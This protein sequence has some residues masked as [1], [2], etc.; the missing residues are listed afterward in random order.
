MVTKINAKTFNGAGNVHNG[1]LAKA[2][3]AVAAA[4]SR[5][6][7]AS[8]SDIT[9]NGGGTNDAAGVKKFTPFTAFQAGTGDGV[10][11]T[12]F[13]AS[14]G[15]VRDALKEIAAQV[16]V[17]RAKVPGFAALTDS[18]GGT[19]ADGTIAAIDDSMTGT[20]ATAA[21]MVAHP[22]ANTVMQALDARTGQLTYFV[23]QLRVALGMSKIGCEIKQSYG[24]TLAAVSTSTGTAT[25][26]SNALADATVSKAQADA[27]LDLMSDNIKTLSTALNAMTA[28]A[29]ANAAMDVVFT[30]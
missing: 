14:A 16:N 2:L 11:K 7:V 1:T 3:H 12:E 19:A 24:T 9:D 29:N 23:N 6:I 20:D 25:G 4:H 28:D 15:A 27:A 22:G 18:M 8:L 30:G 21:T 10:A 5:R 13:E 17:I 26:G